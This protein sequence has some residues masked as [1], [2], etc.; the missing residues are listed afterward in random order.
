LATDNGLNI[1]LAG[2]FKIK[3]LGKKALVKNFDIH[4]RLPW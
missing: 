3:K 1:A 2:Y 4:P